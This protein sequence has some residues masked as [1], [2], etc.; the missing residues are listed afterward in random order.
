MQLSRYVRT[1]IMDV[2]ERRYFTESCNNTKVILIIH[3]AKAMMYIY[4]SIIVCIIHTV[5]GFSSRMQKAS[6]HKAFSSLHNTV[7]NTSSDP[8]FTKKVPFLVQKLPNR[9]SKSDCESISSLVIDVFFKEEAERS[10]EKRSAG[11]ITKPLILAYLKNLQFGDVRGKGFLLGN[12]NN[13][14]FVA[15]RLK[16]I[17]NGYLDPAYGYS[18]SDLND[19]GTVYNMDYLPESEKGYEFGE[20]L[21]FVDITEKAFGLAGIKESPIKTMAEGDDNLDLKNWNSA[22]TRRKS[23]ERTMRPVLTNLSVAPSARSSGVGSALVEMCEQE[24][25]NEWSRQYSEIIL[26][27][28]EEN[29]NAQRFYENRGYIALF[30]DPTSRRFDASGIILRNERTTKICYRKDLSQNKKVPDEGTDSFTNSIFSH[31][32]FFAKIKK[33][34]GVN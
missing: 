5:D 16:S 34:I 1:Y 14:M 17:G 25:M 18:E 6:I 2:E 31:D 10:P 12:T 28:E 4:F 11:F 33:A 8:R 21:G 32:M 15:R 30:S 19:L 20:I 22:S 9:P 3:K 13:S 7:S 29:Q 27:V 24:V 23:D 26:E